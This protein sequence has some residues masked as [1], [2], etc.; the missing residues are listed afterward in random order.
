M[1]LTASHPAHQEV[2]R[3]Y[4]CEPPEVRDGP[5]DRVFEGHVAKDDDFKWLCR[6]NA[7]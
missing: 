5:S 1:G 3:C 6:C 2:L 7:V 4:L